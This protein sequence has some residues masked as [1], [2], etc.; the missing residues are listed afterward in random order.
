MQ[1]QISQSSFQVYR[2]IH[3]IDSEGLCSF[4]KARVNPLIKC[5]ISS[6]KFARGSSLLGYHFLFIFPWPG[7]IHAGLFIININSLPMKR[8]SFK[9]A[10]FNPF[11]WAPCPGLS[12]PASQALRGP[13]TLISGDSSQIGSYFIMPGTTHT[14][15]SSV[16]QPSLTHPFSYYFWI[17]NSENLTSS[18]LLYFIQAK[19]SCLI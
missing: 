15:H 18:R 5:F 1:R 19:I 10:Q 7:S 11:R 16:S 4:Y 8:T 2:L 14:Y 13:K 12:L 17:K 6:Q 3:L 9:E